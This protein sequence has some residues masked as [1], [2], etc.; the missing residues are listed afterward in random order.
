MRELVMLVEDDDDLRENLAFFLD[1]AGVMV[2][3]ASDGR[4]AL[5]MLKAGTR[6]RL[7][8]ADLMMPGMDGWCLRKELLADPVLRAIPFV[9]L[10][11][12]MDVRQAAEALGA[13]DALGKPVDLEKLLSLVARHC[14]VC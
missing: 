7:L 2:V 1:A 11:G 6:P 4:E 3:T 14:G 8:V 13:V 10:S 5:K 9:V 12:A